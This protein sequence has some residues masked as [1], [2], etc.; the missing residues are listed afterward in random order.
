MQEIDSVTADY[1]AAP[2]VKAGKGRPSAVRLVLPAASRITRFNSRTNPGTADSVPVD[3]YAYRLGIV[4]KI[5]NDQGLRDESVHYETKEIPSLCF[6]RGERTDAAAL[7]KIY[8]ARSKEARR[9]QKIG[10]TFV[11]LRDEVT[12]QAI[13]VPFDTAHDV[14]DDPKD[15]IRRKADFMRL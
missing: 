11:H 15:H 1:L 10:G 7:K 4:F 12:G 6:V 5:V 13:V 14:M 8:G 2:P 3:A 9:I